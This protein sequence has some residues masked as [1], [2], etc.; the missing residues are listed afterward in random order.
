MDLHT[1]KAE[2]RARVRAARK[3]I[4]A[5]ERVPASFASAMWAIMLPELHAPKRVLAFMAAPEELDPRVL[6]TALRSQGAEI[7][8]PRI[9][10]PHTLALH[11]YE[12]G[13]PLDAGPFGIS[14]PAD[15]APVVEAESIDVVLVPGVAFDRHG[16]RLG[17]GGG[18]YDRLLAKMPNAY[19]VA[20]AFDVQLVDEVPVG[21]HD[22]P[23][24]V[25]VTPRKAWTAETT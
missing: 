8:L 22:E 21:E 1:R 16:R 9:T 6:R 5:E 2:L 19:R 4:P 15:T 3:E 24:H 14:E 25:V 18:Y 7:A 12:E 11:L 10:G 13:D 17:F 20:L 23:V